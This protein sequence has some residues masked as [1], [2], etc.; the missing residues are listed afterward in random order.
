[1]YRQ[2]GLLLLYSC[3]NMRRQLNR[4]IS[5]GNLSQGEYLVLRNIRL[6]NK[7]SKGDDREGTLKAADLSDMLELSRPSIT[8]ILNTLENRG[9]ITRSIDP[10]DRRSIRMELT[11]AGNEA[12]DLANR[13]IADTAERI[14]ESL[15]EDDTDKLTE[16][17]DKLAEVY[18]KMFE[19]K[20]GEKGERS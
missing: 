15:G 20:E 18:K 5:G 2:K 1:M 13:R 16:L 7:E 9:Y 3:F 19:E 10:K 17:L 6:S 14:A 12:F 11:D 8:R 4:F